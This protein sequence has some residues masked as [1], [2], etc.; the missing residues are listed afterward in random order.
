M[1]TNSKKMMEALPDF[2]DF[3]TLIEEIKNLNYEKMV[4][5]QTIK[6]SEAENF[7][8]V[9]N[10]PQFF[11]GNKPVAVSY[12]EN[13]YKYSG[14]D[15]ETIKHRQALAKVISQLEAKKAQYEVYKQI[16]D[17]FKTLVYQEKGMS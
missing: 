2:N 3:F 10:N 13:A 14:T 17:M 7:N 8:R 11:V 16:V 12:F 4:I 9:M 5:E 1:D 6:E 15:G